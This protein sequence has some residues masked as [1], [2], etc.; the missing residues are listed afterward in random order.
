MNRLASQ[1]LAPV[2]WLGLAVCLVANAQAT[3]NWRWFEVEVLAFKYDEP[4]AEVAEQFPLSIQPL[5]VDRSRDLFSPRLR[6]DL[7]WL[8]THLPACARHD[9]P[10]PELLPPLTGPLTRGPVLELPE[11]EI[12]ELLCRHETAENWV[13]TWY[14]GPRDHLY[15]PLTEAP[16]VMT[17]PGGDIHSAELP[18][19][20]PADELSFTELRER[21]QRRSDTT[22]LVHTSWRQPVFGRTTGR[23]HRLFG[24]RNFTPDYHYSGHWRGDFTPSL[25]P[26]QLPVPGP[27][28]VFTDLERLLQAGDAEGFRV[29]STPDT[30]DVVPPVPELAP[31]VPEKVWEF[32]GL[33]HIYL[34]GNYLHIAGDFN[35]RR[36]AEL[37]VPA[38]ELTAQAEQ[39]LNGTDQQTEPF[40]RAYRFNQLRRVISHQT[41]YFDHPHMGLVIEIRRTD[42]SHRR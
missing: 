18:F 26:Y 3:D 39:W 14:D 31:G 9:F 36:E 35:L 13:T 24:G 4:G 8:Y 10:Y 21:L 42:L 7:R 32:D 33:L 15:F 38:P 2:F 19:L 27:E 28:P 11:P 34:V 41:H 23:Q 30:A 1:L 22:P 12:P 6:T 25:D 29:R 16:E 37:A 40:L 17:G 20:Q 5:A